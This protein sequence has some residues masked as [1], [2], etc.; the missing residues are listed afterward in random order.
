MFLV[1]CPRRR[2]LAFDVLVVAAMLCTIPTAFAQ[3][4]DA[5][6]AAPIGRLDFAAANLPEANAEVDLSREMFQDLFGIG[7]A[8]L[9]GVAEALQSSPQSGDT[10]KATRIAAQQTAALRQIVQLAGEVVREVHVRVY[11]DAPEG[12]EL[13]K[14]F[15]EQ[16]RAGDWETI[17][18]VRKG[19]EVV[20]VAALRDGGAVRGLFV[21]ATDGGELVLA[22]VVCDVSPENAQKLSSAATKIGL[23]N[24]LAK[25]IQ[26]KLES[27]KVFPGAERAPATPPRPPAPDRQ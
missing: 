11:E 27:R 3:G 2:Q 4:V 15:D 12:L 8:A 9:A 22:N 6:D 20:R 19:D 23:E 10:E 24:G 26:L 5:V 25:A 21:M 1:S 13:H 16:L 18:R 7:D 17:A 14:P